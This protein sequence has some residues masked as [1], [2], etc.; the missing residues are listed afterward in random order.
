M[1]IPRPQVL[2]LALLAGCLI[3]GFV[4]IFLSHAEIEQMG[5]SVHRTK[6]SAAALREAQ[7]AGSAFAAAIEALPA[8]EARDPA[9]RSFADAEG[10]LGALR[11]AISRL[12]QT[13]GVDAEFAALE[14]SGDLLARHWDGLRADAAASPLA[15][16]D[17]RLPHLSR[18]SAD[19]IAHLQEFERHLSDGAGVKLEQLSDRLVGAARVMLAAVVVGCMLAAFCAAS[20]LRSLANA[21]RSRGALDE[22]V[23]SLRQRSDQLSEAQHL[24]KLGEWR[25]LHDS[26]EV[27]LGPA[28]LALLRL[29]QGKTL[30]RQDFH[31]MIVEEQADQF[32]KAKSEVLRTGTPRSIDVKM[33]RGDG[34][35]GD[36]AIACKP[37]HDAHGRTVGVF[38]TMQD[39]TERKAAETQLES[40]AYYDPLTGLANRALFNRDLMHALARQEKSGTGCAL[41]LLDLDHFKDVNDSLGHGAG[42]ELLIKVGIMLWRL[43]GRRATLARIGGDEFAVIVT[44]GCEDTALASLAQSITGTLAASIALDRGA[45]DVSVSIG[46]VVAPRDGATAS[47][48]LRNADIALYKAKEK[49][50]NGFVFFSQ[51]LET[52][53]QNRIALARDLR[54]ALATNTGL[55]LHY[56]PQ[57]CLA[58]GKVVGFEALLRW[59]HPERGAVPPSEF[60]PIAEGSSLIADVGRWVL[61]EAA[62]QAKDW[63]AEGHP[64]REVAVN[65]SA[66]QIWHG[67]FVGEVAGILAETGLPP[68][69]L[70]LELT[71]SV[72][73]D[74]SE[75]RVRS[76]FKAL[77]DLGVGLALDD[78]GTDY[79]SLGY[80]AQLPF[81]KLKIDGLF[82]QGCATSQRSAD[83][84]K[85]I[86]ALGRGLGMVV[87][88]EGAECLEE[89]A[90]L[91]EAQCDIVQGFVFCAAMPAADAL[92]LALACDEERGHCPAMTHDVSRISSSARAAGAPSGRLGEAA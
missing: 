44:E 54:I 27:E 75:G 31:G 4:P 12:A 2:L 7:R 34:S 52:A 78:F 13:P 14:R 17:A 91:R 29:P 74:Y 76:V 69:L 85:G 30:S 63:I 81:D 26:N 38:G 79:S 64:T 11:T 6:S 22:A 92:R 83:L 42:D 37:L 82:T 51:D 21:M 77:K 53:A 58:S 71:E 43:L 1:K 62:R 41:M 87:I 65:V 56:Q 45:A 10:H 60:I 86:I 84:L 55:H 61:H 19:V 40:L 46:I 35:S 90:L 67:D 8:R 89:V 70:C 68:H 20:G 23:A 72:M 3:A 49:G 18:L 16:T 28:A 80:L 59:S 73:V 66:A 50:R 39:I 33:R 24:G 57:F 47:D 25:A 5:A 48:L 88:A 9:E 15:A 32:R 36:I